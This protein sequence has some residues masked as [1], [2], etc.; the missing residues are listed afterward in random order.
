VEI[1]IPS[2]VRI[3]ARILLRNFIETPAKALLDF[4]N[5]M[6]VVN[7]LAPKEFFAVL[8]VQQAERKVRLRNAVLGKTTAAHVQISMKR[9][10]MALLFPKWRI[11]DILQ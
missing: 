5:Y 4:I 7:S 6:T 1:I 11:I 8:F 9:N 2:S 10:R 3:I